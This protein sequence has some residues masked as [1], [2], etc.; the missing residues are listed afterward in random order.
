MSESTI[1]R[2][3]IFQL[4]GY[5]ARLFRNNVGVARYRDRHGRE[6]RVVYG[7][8]PGSSDVI[9]WHSI[10][11]R[12]EDVGRRVAVFVAIEVKA[13]SGT[14]TSK[15][16]RFIRAVRRAGGFAGVARSVDDALAAIDHPEASTPR[17]PM[18]EASCPNP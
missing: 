8:C 6:Q 11:I 9:G 15:Q 16:S 14:V 1:L 13:P 18:P 5:G 4:S 10:T 3:I 7:L 12:P 17:L 2:D